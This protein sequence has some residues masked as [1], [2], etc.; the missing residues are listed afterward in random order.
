MAPPANGAAKIDTDAGAP[1]APSRAVI[2]SSWP[3]VASAWP[4]PTTDDHGTRDRVGTSSTTVS[5]CD[6]RLGDEQHEQRP[7]Q[8]F[9]AS[10][11]TVMV[12]RSH[13]RPTQ[14]SAA[15]RWR[16]SPDSP[17]QETTPEPCD[18]ILT[19]QLRLR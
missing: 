17:E 14:D 13:G 16:R 15:A 1:I 6:V 4:I 5:H 18:P 11:S 8:G 19:Q 10:L 3:A 2:T 7:D 12:F 9:H